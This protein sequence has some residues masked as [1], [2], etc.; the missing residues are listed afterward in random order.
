MNTSQVIVDES[1]GYVD[2]RFPV[3]NSRISAEGE[4]DLMVGGTLFGKPVELRIHIRPGI[5]PNEFSD[6]TKS[7]HSLSD[8]IKISL[9]GVTGLNFATT[10]AQLY[11]SNESSF[12]LPLELCLTAVALEGNPANI[13]LEPVKFKLFHETGSTDEEESPEYFEMY[14]NTN[15]PIGLVALNEKDTDFRSGVLNAL[16]VRP[17]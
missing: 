14:L 16:S 13:A 2:F 11:K 6:D 15:L 1:D 10:L 4:A 17:N 9:S 3:L 5:L 7:V 12:R 8:G